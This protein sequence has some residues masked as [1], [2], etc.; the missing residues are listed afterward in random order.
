[1]SYYSK[2]SEP[3]SICYLT[4]PFPLESGE[5]LDA[6]VLAYELSGPPGA[7]VIVVL[8]GISARRHVCSNRNDP[9]PGWWE[10]LAGPGKPLDTNRFRILSIDF[11]GGSG[12]S[13]SSH[14]SYRY[15]YRCHGA[16]FPIATTRD[17]A[18]ALA[19]LLDHLLIPRIFTFV[20]ASFGGAVA[21]A[22]AELFPEKLERLIVVS[23]AHS[24][25]PLATAWRSIQRQI[26]QFGRET[27]R[28]TRAVELAR[29]L[30]MTT[31]RSGAEFTKRF[32]AKRF[33]AG[34]GRGE[35]LFEIDDYLQSRGRE[36]AAR[37]PIDA[38][39]NLSLAL[40]AH[41]VHPEH[42][43]VP[44]AI[45]GVD[46]DVLVPI[47]QLRELKS[48]LAG[49]TQLFELSSIYGHD[50]FLKETEAVGAI[51]RGELVR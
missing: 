6:G 4:N 49:P 9:R 18:R 45:I 28:A 27:G 29:S 46:S 20:G 21:L 51:L 11:L 39:Y 30:A 8:G 36:F 26:L 42:I 43:N 24:S 41:F 40:D 37:F 31:Y 50:A 38:Y 2:L 17:Q 7:P 33:D 34:G 10:D 47:S 13:T 12:Q 19:E 14:N 48:R 5:A 16:G 32:P 44:A 15:P 25:A 1:M 35:C 23:A 3:S 22:F